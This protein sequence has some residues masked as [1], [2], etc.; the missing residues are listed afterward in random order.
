MSRVLVEMRNRVAMTTGFGGNV[1]M[2]DS[3]VRRNVTIRTL[4][5]GSGFTEEIMADVILVINV[6]IMTSAMTYHIRFGQ[7]SLRFTNLIWSVG[8]VTLTMRAVTYQLELR[9]GHYDVICDVFLVIDLILHS[10]NRLFPYFILWIRQ[11]SLYTTPTLHRLNTIKIKLLSIFTLIGIIGFQVATFG[12]QYNVV[13]FTASKTGCVLSARNIRAVRR[14]FNVH[15][16]I[17]FS[18]STLFH[19]IL[20]GLLLYPI[21]RHIRTRRHDDAIMR[22]IIRIVICTA[23]CICS[24]LLYLVVKYIRPPGASTI[25][26]GLS[27]CYDVTINIIAVTSSFADYRLRLFPYVKK[28]TSPRNTSHRTTSPQMSGRENGNVRV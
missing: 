25:F 11:V 9:A 22:M 26:I 18:I 5:R 14:L 13:H 6:I 4:G 24:D 16:P 2:N 10:L 7:R 28:V 15:S 3:D 17:F 19:L 23:V 20:L 12:I 1:T 8:N 27:S 21:I